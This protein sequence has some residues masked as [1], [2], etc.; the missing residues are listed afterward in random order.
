L[1]ASRHFNDVMSVADALEDEELLKGWHAGDLAAGSE[2]FDRYV[3]L[4]VGQLGPTPDAEELIAEVFVR[5]SHRAS[6]SDP[7]TSVHAL[8][9]TIVRE[10]Q[11]THLR[12]LHGRTVRADGR[13][14]KRYAD[15]GQRRLLL[16]LDLLPAP[17][18][19]ILALHLW[20]R[21]S[22]HELALVLDVEI[23][24]ACQRLRRAINAWQTIARAL[25]PL[26]V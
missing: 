17:E 7:P 20:E 3:E 24:D 9:R 6:R 23:E 8:L 22:V 21:L 25:Q 15:R 26:R 2:L 13:A 1:A 19:R 4:L 10:V 16:T 5:L 18:R 11:V 14:P 12:R